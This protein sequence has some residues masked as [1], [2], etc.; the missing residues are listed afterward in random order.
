MGVKTGTTNNDNLVGTSEV[1]SI[2]GLEGD[3]IL[4]G[5]LGL[6]TLDGGSGDDTYIL[7]KIPVLKSE[8]TNVSGLS[9]TGVME[10]M[11]YPVDNQRQIDAI[12]FSELSGLYWGLGTYYSYSR[13]NPLVTE[14][15]SFGAPGG[16][17]SLR[18][19]S[20][21]FLYN[22]HVDQ[23]QIVDSGGN[24]LV[25]S[26]LDSYILGSTLENLE[27]TGSEN[28]NGYGNDLDNRLTGN[29]GKNTLA[30]YGGDDILDG[31]AGA[32]SMQGGDGDDTYY[33]D[34]VGDVVNET[35]TG[36]FD[37]VATSL[38]R[39]V[40]GANIESGRVLSTGNSKMAG[41]ALDNVLYASS[42]DNGLHGSTGFDTVSYEDAG[43]VTINLGI[44]VAQ[45]TGGSGVDTLGGFEAVIGSR[46]N[47]TLIGNAQD[48]TLDGNVGRD[49]VRGEG[50]NDTLMA[51]GGYS[52]TLESTY[53]E[54]TYDEFGNQIGG[55]D[56]WFYHGET[57]DGGTGN[58]FVSYANAQSS[59]VVN[60]ASGFGYATGAIAL[61]NSRPP[62]ET[63]V[64]N[65]VN[66]VEQAISDF[67]DQLW[68][69]ENIIGSSF[70]DVLTGDN[71]ANVLSGRSGA[72]T[73]I[74]GL[75]NDTY[76]VDNAGD[77]VRETDETLSNGGSD[78]VHSSLNAYTL[79]ANVESGRLI[80]TGVAALTG[81][82][83]NNTL[84]AGAGDNVLNGGTG[85]DTVSYV[86]AASAVTVSLA[87][88]AAQATGGSGTDTLIAIENLTGSNYDDKLTGNAAAN[89]LYGGAGN[90]VLNG[91]AGLDRMTGGEGSDTY[92]VSSADDVVIETNA[93]ATTGGNDTVYSYLSAYTLGANVEEGRILA[94]GVAALTGNGLNNTLYTGVGNNVVNGSTGVD[95]ASYVYAG[96][97]V[98]VSLAVTAA[99]ATGGS[100]SD[101]LLG[102]ENL[103]GSNYNDQLTGNAAA[104]LLNGGAGNDVLNGG[105][106]LDRMTGG[107]GSDTYYVSSAGDAVIETNATTS[108]GGSD[109][110]Y[111]YLDAYTL[112][113]NVENGRLLSTGVA[114]LTG[115][116]LDNTLFAAAGNNVLNGST[117]VD[118]ASYAYAGSA[119]SVSLAVTAAQ[120]TG[121]SGSDTLLGIEN[122]TGSNYNDQLTGNAA[123]NLL[124]GGAGNDVLNG[125]ADLD[126]MTGGDGSDT[127]Y[128][129]NIRDVVIETNATASIGGSDTVFSLISVYTLGANVENG[130]LLTTGAAT[131]TGNSLYNTLYSGAGSNVLDGSAGIDSLA[132]TTAQATGG[133]GSDILLAIE[134]LTGSNYDDK[135]TGNTVA[136]LLNGG[137]GNDTLLGGGGNDTLIG[138][139]GKDVLTG[140]IGN[141]IFD[142][143]ALAETG[144]TSSTWDIITDF[145]RGADKLDLST[146]DANS[147]T[148]VNDAFTSVIGSTAA[149]SA[150]GQ[151]KVAGGVLYGNTDADG[152]AEFAIQ[153]IGTNSLTTADFIL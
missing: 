1:D 4:D 35:S 113:A 30:G 125:G 75:G 103:T 47:D 86:Y 153:I 112:G 110:V 143:N 131:L 80:A 152:A 71:G 44:T 106:G 33:V 126:R 97:A 68:S 43:A 39:Y 18:G 10:S 12:F 104:N 57:L 141:D 114:A 88:A 36:G 101:T 149:F 151:L 67:A 118:T 136:N 122:L 26:S 53:Y 108:T 51:E 52:A 117:G 116:S 82:S 5:G 55:F 79:G 134:N 63:G 23:D 7:N 74:G 91:G 115:N 24:D 31:G 150:A 87:V 121:G 140:D 38:D 11:Y 109:T 62:P 142:F 49:L 66:D 78:T 54:T 32:D 123:A 16:I 102:I 132:V 144:L 107:E 17:A 95:T 59:V 6:D 46:F 45:V 83:L 127:Y 19:A 96:S 15:F 72:D 124:N 48:N 73:L 89:L 100:G 14:W 70:N 93:T 25:K 139:T 137:A 98:T 41:N 76:Y 40:L 105:A 58:D 21:S 60:L 8:F 42:G 61:L 130:R 28:I 145:T 148:L 128:V 29:S 37:L 94:T 119:V 81:N 92:Y 69:I 9:I 64:G 85:V 129:D 13:G 111:S 133:S 22:Y 65:F 147:A 34:N 146:L 84:F 120:A 99:Q 90:D 56:F 20:D 3:D 50:G 135:L 138:S 27:L 77:V 2:I